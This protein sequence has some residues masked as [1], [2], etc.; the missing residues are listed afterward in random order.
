[1]PDAETEKK[2]SFL[3]KAGE[4]IL[5]VGAPI[6]RPLQRLSASI[7][8]LLFR[9]FFEPVWSVRGRHFQFMAWFAVVIL[10]GLVATWLPFLL[11]WGRVQNPAGTLTTAF[12]LQLY[13][14][15]LGSF[16]VPV[17][18]EGLVGLLLAEKAGSNRTAAGVRGIV[19]AFTVILMM[20][21]VGIMGAE[22]AVG[23][24]RDPDHITPKIHVWLAFLSVGMAA[25]L[26][27]F[28]LPGWEDRLRSV[29]EVKQKEDEDV[30]SLADRASTQNK[31]GD[32]AL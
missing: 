15:T 32:I 7:Y 4:F 8:N 31:E 20:L 9:P 21:T 17:L 29:D 6:I 19:G 28:R 30:V 3:R 12:Q 14:G 5:K 13:T 2:K 16:C 26:Y 1:M 27:C 23:V 11:L 18:A 10:L 24:G 25:Y 22:S